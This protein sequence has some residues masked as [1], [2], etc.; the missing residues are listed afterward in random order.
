MDLKEP[1]NLLLLLGMTRLELGGS[2]WARLHQQTGGRVPRV[3]PAVARACYTG[4]HQAIRRGLVRSCHDLSEGGLAVAL[5]EMA[6]AGGLGTRVALAGVP[7]A[8]QAACDY[9]L[10]FSES[11]SRF[12]LEVRADCYDEL[13]RL[14]D[15]LPLGHLGEVT[16]GGAG[17]EA[18]SPRLTVLALDDSVVIDAKASELKAAWQRPLAWS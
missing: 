14:L 11:P 1:G 2:L 12:V 9:V 7:R 10:L 13:A 3:D 15:G 16:S 4:L 6:M 8:D 5:A 17:L 18:A